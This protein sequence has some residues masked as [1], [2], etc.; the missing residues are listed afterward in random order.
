ME[1]EH[2]SEVE[3]RAKDGVY[4]YGVYLDGARYNREQK[5]IDDQHPVSIL[6]SPLSLPD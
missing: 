4:I 1:F 6:F 2:A 5:V 3:E